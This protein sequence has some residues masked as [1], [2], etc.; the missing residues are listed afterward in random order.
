MI[1]S[2]WRERERSGLTKGRKTGGET[3]GCGCGC[4]LNA[5]EGE[6]WNETD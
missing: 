6:R 5:R 4:G 2:N 3:G 1:L